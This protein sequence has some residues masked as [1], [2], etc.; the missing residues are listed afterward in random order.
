MDILCVAAVPTHQPPSFSMRYGRTSPKPPP[1]V[2]RISVPKTFETLGTVNADGQRFVDDLDGRHSSAAGDTIETAFL[3][4]GI[5]A[6]NPSF[7][8]GSAATVLTI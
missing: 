3:H 6:L 8:F 1:S 2:R 4:R 7:Q 5:C